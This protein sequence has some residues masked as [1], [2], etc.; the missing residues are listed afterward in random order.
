MSR[1]T[2]DCF[3]KPVLK[4]TVEGFYSLG[5]WSA[6][7]IPNAC[8]PAAHLGDEL[9]LHEL[10]DGRVDAKHVALEGQVEVLPCSLPLPTSRVSIPVVRAQGEGG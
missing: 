6:P 3:V 7:P 1:C 2:F 9:A 8:R 5:S 10:P 4:L